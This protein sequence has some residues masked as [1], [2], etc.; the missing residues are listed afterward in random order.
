MQTDGRMTSME[1]ERGRINGLDRTY[2]IV[3]KANG[4][5]CELYGSSM[6]G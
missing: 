4:K 1:I 3:E 6:G 2:Q 5:L